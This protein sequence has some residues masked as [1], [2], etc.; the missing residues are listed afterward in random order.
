MLPA[1]RAIRELLFEGERQGS[2]YV[3]TA[4]IFKAGC[5]ER[6]FPVEGAVSA[7]DSQIV[8]AGKVARFDEACGNGPVVDQRLVFERR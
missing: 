6:T 4:R 3:G 5:G 7:N 2:R 8:L 1:S